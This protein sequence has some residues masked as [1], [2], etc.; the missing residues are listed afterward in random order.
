MYTED[1]MKTKLL[2]LILAFC[3]A[4]CALCACRNEQAITQNS[5][6]TA[7]TTKY[8]GYASPAYPIIRAKSIEELFDA[9]EE[10]YL[11]TVYDPW[12][13][14]NNITTTDG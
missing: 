5:A 10:C 4:A 3:V 8:T 14:D 11:Y 13:Y 6:T 2:A 12:D 7:Y 9:I 1:F